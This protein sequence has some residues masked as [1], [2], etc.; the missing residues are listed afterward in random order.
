MLT[1][2]RPTLIVAQESYR[3]FGEGV[4]PRERLI[5]VH[6]EHRSLR[7]PLRWV[8]HSDRRTAEEWWFHRDVWLTKRLQ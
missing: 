1:A 4:K 3:G 5:R 2:N 6:K 8:L 7:I